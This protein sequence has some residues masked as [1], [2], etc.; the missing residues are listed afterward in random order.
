[1]YFCEDIQWIL[2]NYYV[3][4]HSQT[5]LREFNPVIKGIDWVGQGKFSNSYDFICI[6]LK[7]NTQLISLESEQYGQSRESGVRLG[8]TGG[9]EAELVIFRNI[10]QL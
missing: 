9:L 3:T 6:K 7:T 1:M 2:K 5:I 4:P 8:E 10:L